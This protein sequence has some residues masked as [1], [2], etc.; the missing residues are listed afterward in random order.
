MSFPTTDILLYAIRI[1]EPLN[2]VKRTGYLKQ[3]E[4]T[5]R[6]SSFQR[7][8][9]EPRYNDDLYRVW[10]FD[11][12][13]DAQEQLDME[14]SRSGGLTDSITGEQEAQRKREVVTV[15]VSHNG[16]RRIVQD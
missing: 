5:E 10:L 16:T 4:F 6:K 12:E 11:S 2:G 15:Q 3:C 1:Q 9:V 8:H 7:V 13:Q 14:S